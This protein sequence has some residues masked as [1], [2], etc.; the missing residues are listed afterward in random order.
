MHIIVSVCLSEKQFILILLLLLHAIYFII[1]LIILLST[2]GMKKVVISKAEH[3]LSASIFRI[4][5]KLKVLYDYALHCHYCHE[6]K[7]IISKNTWRWMWCSESSGKIIAAFT[8]FYWYSQCKPD[9]MT[10]LPPT[11]YGN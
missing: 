11:L 3:F 5:T 4:I 9:S 7:H 8:L 10:T 6:P 1:F 2:Y